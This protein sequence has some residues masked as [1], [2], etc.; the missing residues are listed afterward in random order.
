[1]LGKVNLNFSKHVPK[2][3]KSTLLNTEIST[4]KY[5]LEVTAN[6]VPKNEHFSLLAVNVLTLINIALPN[7]CNQ[8][9]LCSYARIK[10]L[11]EER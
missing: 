6:R 7:I 4:N 3:V 5:A 2:F 9:T 11:R 8:S 1:M 10:E